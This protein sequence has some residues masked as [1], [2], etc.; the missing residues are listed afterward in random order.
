[1]TLKSTAFW[2]SMPLLLPQAL[3]V[4]KTATRLPP[5]GGDTTGVVGSGESRRLLGIG[6]SIIAGVGADA[7]HDALVAQT[8]VAIATAKSC[9]VEWQA[10]GV[11]GFTTH[12]IIEKLLP[13]L[14]EQSVDDFVISA[15]VNDVTGL[16]F[17]RTYEAGLR[18]LIAALR[19]H[20]PDARIAMSGLPPLHHF[21]L[22]PQPLRA[23]LGLRARQLD[24]V[25]SHV[26]TQMP[27][28]TYVPVDFSPEP[29]RFAT[30]GYHPS[31]LG[32]AEY[33]QEVADALLA[34]DSKSI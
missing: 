12:R 19:R 22:L 11:S 3:Y 1:M 14:P 8:A 28:T 24:A 2:L 20:S 17:R 30:D 9:Q 7:S 4:R 29:E 25:A 15:G 27:Q 21:P 13:K 23:V 33:G 31:A 10:I 32:Y 34:I 5:A 6:D 18:Q 26:V 16:T